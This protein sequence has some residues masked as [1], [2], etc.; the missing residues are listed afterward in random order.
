MLLDLTAQGLY[1]RLQ[2]FETLKHVQQSLI[3]ECSFQF[4]EALH[5]RFIIREHAMSAEC[6]EEHS[7]DH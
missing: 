6:E 3:V 2:R 4:G 7:H 5:Q 1:F